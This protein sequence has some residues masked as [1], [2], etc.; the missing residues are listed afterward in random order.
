MDFIQV[1]VINFVKFVI[2]VCFGCA[3]VVLVSYFYLFFKL[4][5][6]KD[7]QHWKVGCW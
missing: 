4:K 3:E 6:D 1:L 5:K 7:S 2:N